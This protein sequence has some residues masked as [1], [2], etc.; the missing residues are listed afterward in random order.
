MPDALEGLL[1][2]IRDTRG[3]DFT[4]YKRS[5]LTRRI[6][7]RVQAVGAASYADYQD[8]LEVHPDEFA[9][10]F[11][12][13]LIN[14]TGFFRDPAVWDYLR[15]DIVPTMLAAKGTA[16][17]VR[18]WS[19]GCA[20]GEEAYSVAMLLAESMGL[21]AYR[22]RVK[23]YATDLDEDALNHGRAAAYSAKQVAGVPQHLLDK[24]FDQAA[25]H[26]VCS[27]DLRRSVIFGR[28]DLL[29]D[30]PI[31]RIDL[32]VCRNTLMYFNAEGQSQVVSRF[33][34]ALN[35]T[36]FLFLGKAE[37]LLS[38]NELFVPVDLKRRVFA[39]ATRR[40]SER[41]SA[42]DVAAAAL[43]RDERLR[44][45]A[46]NAGL[47]AQLT[48][49]GE[50]V[51]VLASDE[52]R[53]RFGLSA[54]DLGSPFRDLDL[55][56]RPVD[57]RSSLD[58]VAET[59]QPLRIRDVAVEERGGNAGWFDVAV[60]PLLAADGT[61][62]GASITF[63]DVTLSH[64]L[65]AELSHANQELETAYEEL[66]STNEE[67][68]TTNEELQSTVEELET[69]NEEL[70]STNEELE[71][72]NEELQSSNEELQTIND[73]LRERTTEL[74]EVNVYVES[75][76]ASL[77][78]AVIV[79]DHELRVRIWSVHAQELWGV[80]RDE[81]IDQHFFDLDIGLPVDQLRKPVRAC[82]A[83]EADG[84]E[85]RVE[86][87]NRRGKDII[88]RVGLSPLRAGDRVTA[89]ILLIET[90]PA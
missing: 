12:T 54:A 42:G 69:T 65:Q 4:G 16:D 33:H 90:E 80:R 5:T 55:S 23:I 57:L 25:S 29:Q 79:V 67:L 56:Y 9:R 74:N 82:L 78:G 52:A 89:V 17:P 19:A 6:D 66:Q 49:D 39:M 61:R 15:D 18:V 88:C 83:G 3:F 47:T 32:L 22:D 60:V 14:V 86:A 30:A 43:A 2:H 37:M 20:S 85:V 76:L 46:Y 8:Y 77:R 48:V 7:K 84:Q 44:E 27:A 40:V 87:T 10:L 51:L 64:R 70:Q 53:R 36:G 21:D 59:G 1:E 72:M 35:D 62:L 45:L 38:R 13:M 31:S 81:V 73:E 68:E 41:A 50:G 34:F 26:Y 75:I 11:D 58:Q 24:Y 71:T 28:H 63:V